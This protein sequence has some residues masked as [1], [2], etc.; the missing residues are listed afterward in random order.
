MRAVTSETAFPTNR[1]RSRTHDPSDGPALLRS[2]AN[3]DCTLRERVQCERDRSQSR[4]HRYHRT[5]RAI[6]ERETGRPMKL[7]TTHLR[8]IRSKLG[9]AARLGGLKRVLREAT[10]DEFAAVSNRRRKW[11]SPYRRIASLRWMREWYCARLLLGSCR[12]ERR[13]TLQST[14]LYELDPTE[15]EVLG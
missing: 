12:Q 11:D 15:N 7:A 14:G 13:A 1:S 6:P 3:E 8:A 5:L 4:A 9:K 10:S 2:Q